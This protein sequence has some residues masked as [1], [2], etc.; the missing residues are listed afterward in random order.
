MKTQKM[1]AEMKKKISSVTFL[2]INMNL[3]P[4]A[5]RHEN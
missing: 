5:H 1:D 3:N 4:H 2:D